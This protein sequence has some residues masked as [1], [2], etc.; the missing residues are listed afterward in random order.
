VSEGLAEAGTRRVIAGNTLVL[1]VPPGGGGGIDSFES[2]GR[3]DVK[4]L[5]IGEPKTV[6]AGSTPSRRWRS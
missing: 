6:P 4:R 5:A 1:V 3:A 2:L